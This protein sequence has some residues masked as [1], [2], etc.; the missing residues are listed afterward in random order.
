[1]ILS[2][3][4]EI[5]MDYAERSF[6]IVLT[7]KRWQRKVCRA[8]S[9]GEIDSVFSGFLYVLRNRGARADLR[10]VGH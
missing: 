10:I 9:D 1:M 6:T 4:S 8:P 3:F 5:L 7:Q 2:E